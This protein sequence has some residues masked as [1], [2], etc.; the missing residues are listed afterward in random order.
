MEAGVAGMGGDKL[1][2]AEVLAVN[3]G[4]TSI[5]VSY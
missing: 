5:Y 3:S 4:S 2:V 1:S